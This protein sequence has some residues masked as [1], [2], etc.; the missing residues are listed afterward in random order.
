MLV[1][2]TDFQEKKKQR[3]QMR[4][5]NCFNLTVKPR[6][7]LALWCDLA[8]N[9]LKTTATRMHDGLTHSKY[10]HAAFNMSYALASNSTVNVL[11]QKKL[12]MIAQ[13]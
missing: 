2:M 1:E 12:C 9:S 13:A 6:E 10:A 8:T 4:F 5:P 3:S 11:I 7:G